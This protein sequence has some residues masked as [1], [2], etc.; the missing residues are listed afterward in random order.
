MSLSS[1]VSLSSALRCKNSLDGRFLR[2]LL[3]LDVVTNDNSILLL[4]GFISVC[5][6]LI[7]SGLLC[8]ISDVTVIGRPSWSIW[9]VVMAVMPLLLETRLDLL[10]GLD[11]LTSLIGIS[12][13]LVRLRFFSLRSP[14]R[15]REALLYLCDLFRSLFEVLSRSRFLSCKEIEDG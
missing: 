12:V 2:F 7:L 1:V 6:C 15:V 14:F 3:H 9:R 5:C 4:F 13:D 8:L 10:G 11:I